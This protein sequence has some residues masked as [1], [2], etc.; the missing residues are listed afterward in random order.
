MGGI[1]VNRDESAPTV[2]SEEQFSLLLEAC[3]DALAAGIPAR[4]RLEP[5][6]SATMRARLDREIA[7]CA[8]VRSLWC[9]TRSTIAASSSDC[10]RPAPRGVLP[11]ARL[12]RFQIRRE[13]GRGGFG[14]VYLAF[15]PKLGRE[16]A[17]KV[18]RPEVLMQ[19][20]LRSRFHQEAR[21]AASLDH[22]NVV[23]VYDAGEDGALCYIASAYCPGTTLNAWLKGRAEPVPFGLAARLVA[24]LAEALEHAH[25]RGI[26]HRDLKPSNVMLSPRPGPDASSPQAPADGMDFVPRIMD[27]G[28][29]KVLGDESAA[30]VADHRTESGAIVG[31]PMYMAPE[32]AGG[33]SVIGPA[34][35]V[36]ALGA[37]LYELLTG[38]PPFR[39]DDSVETLVLVRTQEPLAPGRLRPNL[40]RDLETIC[41]KCLYKDPRKRYASAQALADD[42]LRY[43]RREPIQ[44]RRVG[45]LGRAVL[46]CRRKPALAATIA[47][48]ALTVAVVAG[49]SGYQVLQER[50]RYR[51]ERDRAESQRLRA[52]A[53]L[54]QACQA[55]DQML[56]RVGSERLVPVP[57][58]MKVRIELFEDAVRFYE[59]LAQQE[60]GDPEVRAELIRAYLRLGDMY[61]HAFRESNKAERINRKALA[62]AEQLAADFP[63]QPAYQKELA[64]SLKALGLLLHLTDRSREAE[65]PLHQAVSLWEK[66][67]IEHP[68]TPSFRSNCA[69]ALEALGILLASTGRPQEA[70]Q[71]FLRSVALLDKLTAENQPGIDCRRNLANCLANLGFFLAMENDRRDEARKAYERSLGVWQQ[72]VDGSPQDPLFRM[73]LALAMDEL[74]TLLAKDV[75]PDEGEALLRRSLAIR[76]QLIVDHPNVPFY[77]IR[78]GGTLHELAVL[79]RARGALAEACQLWEQAVA[80]QREGLKAEL[81]RAATSKA[82]DL[83]WANLADTRLRLG[84]HRPAAQAAA[85]LPLLAPEDCQSYYRAACL[86]ARCA[87]VA[88]KDPTIPEY[89][90]QELCRAY[91]DQ[92]VQLL[93]QA[94]G[95]GYQDLTALRKDP[96]LD[97]L[98]PRADFQ[99]LLSEL[100]AR[101]TAC[102]GAAGGVSS[103]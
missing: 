48:A 20:D 49:A 39:G 31:T 96:D 24:T 98:R 40:P 43:L 69:A 19:P 11:P 51:A 35:D 72:L 7:W 58:L 47:L 2:E 68:E 50:D 78:L 44:A 88:A 102:A 25:R 10:S 55:V 61:H 81:E 62:L 8:M 101:L 38:R 77:Y 93:G 21:A 54:R 45:V 67:V 70:E 65:A 66:L 9:D 73:R 12:G 91:A 80:A 83:S 79:V 28:L 82:L 90:R 37:M 89:K 100:A 36:H 64:E 26:L 22:P 18:P 42:L 17:L 95:K 34:T 53:H 92:A 56:T 75:R 23:A 59:E 84:E 60:D 103:Q 94:I 85:E 97:V 29:A 15:D 1:A 76:K 57:H 63:G 27:F 6:L 87:S 52:Q 5:E 46:W 99:R 13:L 4:S 86:L 16:V 3:D 30:A 32:Q 41:L 71:A 33:R 14:V 74:G